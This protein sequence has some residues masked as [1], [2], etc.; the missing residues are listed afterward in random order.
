MTSIF[1]T[2]LTSYLLM[3][4][5]AILMGFIAYFLAKKN[6]LL[7]NRKFIFYVLLGSVILCIPAL[8][9]FV[10]YWFMPYIYILLQG[11]YLL[12]GYYNVVFLKHFLPNIKKENSFWV[13]FLIQFLMMFIGAALF[14]TVF[15]LCNVLKYG[16]WACTCLLTFMF[17][18]LFWETYNKYMSIPVEI[19]K[20]WKFIGGLDFSSFG[21]IDYNKSMVMELELFK[22]MEDAT[23]T[24]IKAKA[25]GNMPFG[26]W[27]N[28]FLLDYNVKFPLSMIDYDSDTIPYGWIFYIKRSFFLPRRYVD[29]ELSIVENRIK[30][31][32]TIIAKRVSETDNKEIK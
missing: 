13:F 28:K 26:V 29:Y 23:P 12:L 5:I 7:S 1:S 2:F 22:T 8:L 20:V 16:L 10:D 4:L 9:G 15:N 3:P 31:K 17:P 6:K 14:S 19:Y 25:P 11:L 18:P 30:E 27:F 24:K 32:Y 21:P